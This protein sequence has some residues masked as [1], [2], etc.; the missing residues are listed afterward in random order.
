[1]AVR[2]D[3]FVGSEI[4]EEVAGVGEDAVDEEGMRASGNAGGMPFTSGLTSVVG[5]VRKGLRSVTV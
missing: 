5:G 2:P 4:V 1:M 3:V